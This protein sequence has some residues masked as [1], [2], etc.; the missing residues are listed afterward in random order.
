M[1]HVKDEVFIPSE[2]RRCIQKAHNGQDFET[3]G[4]CR[5]NR[6]GMGNLCSGTVVSATRQG[7]R[8]VAALLGS[9]NSSKTSDQETPD[10]N[11]IDGAFKTGCITIF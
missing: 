7:R 8:R 6:G 11:Q 9:S 2:P 5:H 1:L 3:E 4:R 10:D